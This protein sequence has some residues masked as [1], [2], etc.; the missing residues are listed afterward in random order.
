MVPKDDMAN[1]QSGLLNITGI[2]WVSM[3]VIGGITRS[4]IYIEPY[5]DIPEDPDTP[6]WKVVLF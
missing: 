6:A 1:D 2:M 4:M 5:F 3:H